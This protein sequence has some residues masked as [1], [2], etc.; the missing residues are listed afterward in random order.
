[1]RYALR[2]A[3]LAGAVVLTYPG[4]LSAADPGGGTASGTGSETKSD[5][6]C[7]Y[8]TALGNRESRG[9]G[10]YSA[11]NGQFKGK[12]QMG[13]DALED[14]GY[15][16][17]SG[18]WKGVDG[19]W[20][21]SDWK[22]RPDIQEKVQGLW[23]AKLDQYARTTPA[24]GGGKLIDLVG[25]T[26]PGS[27]IVLTKEGLRAGIHLVGPGGAQAFFGSGGVCSST[28]IAGSPSGRRHSTADRSGTCFKDYAAS[29]GNCKAIE[30]DMSKKTC[31]VTMPMIEGID[32]SNFSGELQSFC[33]KTK[34]HLM[35]RGE[36]NSAESWA[37]RAPKGPQKE[38]CEGQTFGPGTGSWSYVLACSYMDKV[39]AD[40]D[41]VPN[42][43]GGPTKDPECMN[44][45]RGMGV[46]FDELG[47]HTTGSYNGTTCVVENAI[48]YRGKAISLGSRQIMTCELAYNL[49]K[50]GEALRGIGAIGYEE[51]GSIRKCMSMIDDRGAYGSAKPTKHAL[52]QAIDIGKMIH[53]VH[54]VVPMGAMRNAPH[55]PAGQFAIEAGQLACSF[56]DQ[57]LSPMYARYTKYHHFHL[58]K[59]GVKNCK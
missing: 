45:L 50:Y 35:T 7:D 3:L 33:Q 10:G 38:S 12:Y 42:Q 44:K 8:N 28:P 17:S 36:C 39:D 58:E 41:G 29:I 23:N 22:S 57:V 24:P 47:Q 27:N 48:A 21:D 11:T 19:I 31:D 54:G 43:S 51:V 34:P 25:K 53:K 32:C 16:D 56:F 26:L 1:M 14:V 2:A 55:T 18:R 59:A 40:N 46:E 49:E 30:K 20:T 5:S 9:S 13:N 6:E 37:E 15:K 4:G 52:G